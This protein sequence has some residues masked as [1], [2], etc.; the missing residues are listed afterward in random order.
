MKLL[1]FCV[2]L[3]LCGY[4]QAAKLLCY[5]EPGTLKNF[6]IGEDEIRANGSV[7]MSPLYQGGSKSVD[8]TPYFL[9]T[10]CA[11]SISTLQDAKGVNFAGGTGNETPAIRSLSKWLCEAKKVRNDPKVR[12]L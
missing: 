12:Q 1:T 2:V 6:C 4:A 8:K 3:M 11:K 7:R 5:E 10:D 9:L